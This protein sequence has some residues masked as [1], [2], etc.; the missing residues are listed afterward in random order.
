MQSREQANYGVL[1]K[2]LLREKLFKGSAGIAQR[3]GHT[4][5]HLLTHVYAPACEL[6]SILVQLH[7]QTL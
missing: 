6:P 4:R 2:Q 1:E 7:E 3:Q 5:D